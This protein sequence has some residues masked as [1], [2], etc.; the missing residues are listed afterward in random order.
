[1]YLDFYQ[2][3]EKPFPISSGLKLFFL[4]SSQK[5]ALDLLAYGVSQRKGFMAILGEFGL[6]KTTLIQAFLKEANQG[7]V[8]I[9]PLLINCLKIVLT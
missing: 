3:K 5:D 7:N 8:Q 2:L 1:M 9:I 6:G 4:S